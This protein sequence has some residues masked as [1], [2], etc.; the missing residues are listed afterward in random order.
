MHCDQCEQTFR[1]TACTTIGV[2]GKDPDME[3]LQKILLYGLKGMAS[4]KAHARRLGKTDPDVEA[5]I[6][7]ALFATVTNVNFDIPSLLELVLKCGEM[8]LRT[9]QLLND[10]HVEVMG[11]PRPV[12]VTE[13]LHEGP[14]I[15]VT[16]HD[17]VDLKDLLE[18]TAGMGIDVYT[19][20]E[21]LPGHMYENLRAHP[22]LRGHYGGAWQKQRDEFE[23]F[24]GP[25]LAT[26]NCVLIPWPSN[27]YLDRLFTVRET[28][29]PGAVRLKTSDFSAVI[30][31]A[32]QIGSLPATPRKT[33]TIGFHHSVILGLA[34]HIVQA[35][36]E[37][38]IKH[39]YLIGG[40][41]GAEP[42]RN[43]FRDFASAAPQDSLIM[44]MGCG[45]YR[46]R[47]QDFGTIRLNGIEIPRLLDLG[48][49]NDSYGAIQVALGLAKAFDC[50]INDLPLTLLVSW[51]EQKAVAVLLTLLHLGMK[52]IRL[53]P[54]LP[55]FV[56]PNVLAI[57]QEKYNLQGIGK[58][59]HADALAAMCG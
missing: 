47:D 25:V 46:I 37:G 15:L 16:G 33:S 14:R 1:G 20:G 12:E 11:A 43:Y 35:V 21:M 22:H 45:K 28:A 44:T 26:T 52:G 54:A 51:F 34:D 32:R 18:Q 53:G 3:S 7:E 58:D 31:K 38:Q 56:S 30:E 57:L 8:N 42:G 55:A 4:Y 13:G 23:A 27:T 50:G 59:G 41:D 39:F 49:C 5:F 10:G 36:R 40:C 17:M 48:Q 29:V 6:E 2:C 24:G 9:M 19:H